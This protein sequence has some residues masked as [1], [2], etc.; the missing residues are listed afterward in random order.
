LEVKE[1]PMFTKKKTKERLL[2]KG[3]SLSTTQSKGKNSDKKPFKVQLLERMA[4]SRQ[5]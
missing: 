3:R 4:T 2:E 5:G 1:K